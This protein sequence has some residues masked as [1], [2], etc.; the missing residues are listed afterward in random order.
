MSRSRIHH[1]RARFHYGSRTS[2][3][4]LVEILIVLVI[5][6]I[7]AGLLFPAF[8]G[9]RE[10]GKR[11]A[12]QS[13]LKQL[14]LGFL[15]YVQDAGGR[16]PYAANFQAWGNGGHWVAGTNGKNLAELKPGGNGTYD[17][18]S[19][20]TANVEGGAIYP[21]IKNA[22]V[23][24]CP[25]TEFGEDKRLTYSMNCALSGLHGV[26][27]K[28]PSEIVLLVDEAETLNDGWFFATNTAVG[29]TIGESTDAATQS[30][31]DANLLFV[32]GHAKSFPPSTFALDTSEAGLK[33]KGRLKPGT[34]RFHD[35]AF[36]SRLG[37]ATT[38]FDP[39]G[40][41]DAT[42]VDSCSQPLAGPAP[43]PTTPP[44]TP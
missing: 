33:N 10:S 11:A 19:P 27:L 32:D 1:A 44:T 41:L 39:G 16:Y 25:S 13:N 15:Q 2:G 4:T 17:W 26:R 38:G 43:A 29:A 20:N 3:F 30:H 40:G 28:A 21:Y 36:G 42:T 23:Y 35:R 9:A 6:M 34:V 8:Q 31:G 12:C 37:N 18:V 22:E 7:L 24:I 14:G 5:I